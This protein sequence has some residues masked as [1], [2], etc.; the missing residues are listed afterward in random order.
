VAVAQ[1]GQ[2]EAVVAARVLVVADADQGLGEQADDDRE[3]LVPR[4]PALAQVLREAAAQLRQALAEID[5]ARELAGVAR[6]PP[7]RVVAVLLAPAR[8]WPCGAALQIA[9]G[10][11]AMTSRWRCGRASVEQARARRS[12]G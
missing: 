2:A 1:R 8:G 6:A 4:Q 3:H 5:Q 10:L 7:L 11:G 12:R 9:G